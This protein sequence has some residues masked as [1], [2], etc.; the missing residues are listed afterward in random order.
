MGNLGTSGRYSILRFYGFYHRYFFD[1][2]DDVCFL[3]LGRRGILFSG[4]KG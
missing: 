1:Q 3:S 4:G 2:H